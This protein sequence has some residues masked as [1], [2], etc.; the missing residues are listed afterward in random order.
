MRSFLFLCLTLAATPASA[1]ASQVPAQALTPAQCNQLGEFAPSSA[2]PP[3]LQ[4]VWDFTMDTQPRLSR[5]FL[6]LGPV[7][8][9][10]AGSLTP[11][12]TNS[13]AIRTLVVQAAAVRMVVASREGDVVFTG[14]LKGDGTMM[15]GTVAYHGGRVFPMIVHQRPRHRV[16]PSR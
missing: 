1:Q 11:Y 15:C 3:N 9:A 6:V 4:G 8:G 14:R 13:L 2:E 7:D 10:W 5:G 12:A 16:Y